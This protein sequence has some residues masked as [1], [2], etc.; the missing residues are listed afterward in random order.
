MKIEISDDYMCLHDN[1]R[2]IATARKRVDGWWNVSHWPRFFNRDQ[3][4][5]ALTVNE[6]LCSGRHGNDPLVRAPREELR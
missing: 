1:N 5:T 4:I 2:T 6:L 3:A